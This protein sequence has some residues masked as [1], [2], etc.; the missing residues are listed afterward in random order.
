[1]DVTGTAHIGL[2]RHVDQQSTAFHTVP[3]KEELLDDGAPPF[4]SSSDDEPPYRQTERV[5]PIPVT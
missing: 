5:T 2:V 4:I 3:S 1:M